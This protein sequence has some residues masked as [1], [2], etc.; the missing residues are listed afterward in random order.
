VR[1][2]ELIALAGIVVI[3]L[4]FYVMMLSM[5]AVALKVIPDVGGIERLVFTIVAVGVA[6]AFIASLVA[7][8]LE[9]RI[10]SLT[11]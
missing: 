11:G 2:G 5:I 9:A 4:V 3:F 6:L 1:P 8:L 7:L 10:A